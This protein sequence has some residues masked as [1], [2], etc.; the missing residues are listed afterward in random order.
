[1]SEPDPHMDRSCARLQHRIAVSIL[2]DTRLIA[3]LAEAVAILREANDSGVP[4]LEHGIRTHRIG[5]MRQ[6]AILGAAGID[7]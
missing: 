3:A 6:R 4:D 1:M 7:V 5:I 2:L